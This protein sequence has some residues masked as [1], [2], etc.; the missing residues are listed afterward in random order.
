MIAKAYLW[1]YKNITIMNE[2]FEIY[3]KKHNYA[4]F[5]LRAI[6][7]DMDGVLYDS[8]KWHASS[9]HQTMSEFGIKSTLE[10]FY[11]YEG[12]VGGSTINHVIN[13]EKGRDASSE[14]IESIYK[15]KSELFVK[16][17]DNSLIP[18]AYNFVKK[19]RD[20]G[21][22]T[23]IV[24]GSGQ[25]SLI[26]KVQHSFSGLF[27]RDD[28][29]TA[30]DVTNGKPHPE[31]YLKGLKKAGDL[32][33]NQAIVVENAPKGVESAVSAG[34]FCIAI[35]T[36]PLPDK[37]LYDAGADIVLPS[38]HSLYNHWNEYQ[39]FFNKKEELL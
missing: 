38:M 37:L 7:F 23:L 8:M 13:R 34:I 39:T 17:N 3:L 15:R 33:S 19:V 24:T 12:M 16:Y 32:E 9:W 1:I 25:P 27:N 6:L 31:P 22:N 14:E 35:N 18:Y 11:L 5:D 30:H 28:M 26:E 2:A 21:L 20:E 29:V 10:E 4:T 36:G